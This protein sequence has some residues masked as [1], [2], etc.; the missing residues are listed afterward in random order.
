VFKIQEADI[1]HK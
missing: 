1:L